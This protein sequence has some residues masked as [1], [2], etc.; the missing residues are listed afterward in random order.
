MTKTLASGAAACCALIMFAA[1][2]APAEAASLRRSV[3][4]DASPETVWSAIGP[5]CAIAAWHPAI[6]S[7]A[8]DARGPVV[9]TL[10]TKD[11]K[12]TFVEIQTA[13]SQAERSYSYTFK[14]APIPVTGYASTLRVLAKADGTSTVTW[15]G[16]YTPDAG[17]AKAADEAL[18]GIYESG[19]AAIKA[20]FAH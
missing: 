1:A 17:Q 18:A 16:A 12:A 13:R 2:A 9:R 7:C 4:V 19:L 11:G 20:R 6:G 15:S 5:F 3:D 14:S 10:V 8:E